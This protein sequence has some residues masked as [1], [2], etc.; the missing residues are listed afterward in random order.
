MDSGSGDLVARAEHR[1]TIGT[2]VMDG[3]HACRAVLE[4]AD[5]GVAQG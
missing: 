2:D 5:R 3:W 4:E 1:T